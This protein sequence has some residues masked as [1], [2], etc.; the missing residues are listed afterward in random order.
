MSGLAC[1]RTGANPL[2]MAG[3]SVETFLLEKSRLCS[4][5]QGERNFK[6]LYQLA[7]SVSVSVPWGFPV[8]ARCEYPVSARCD[9]PLTVRCDCPPH[10]WLPLPFRELMAGNRLASGGHQCDAICCVW[11]LL[12]SVRYE[13]EREASTRGTEGAERAGD[14]RARGGERVAGV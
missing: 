8:S 9:C 11:G 4:F 7:A 1:A 12:L 14:Q 2:F 3:A 13:P 10:W 6:G 5:A